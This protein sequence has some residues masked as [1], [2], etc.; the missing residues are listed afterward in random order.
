MLPGSQTRLGPYEI[1]ALLGSTGAGGEMYKATDTRLNRTVAI[2]LLNRPEAERLEGEARVIAALNN[3]YICSIYDIGTNYIVM[4]YVD[5]TALKSPLP[6]K[7]CLRF[8]TQLATA[9][10]A[11]HALGIVH[12]NLKPTNILVSRGNLKLLDFGHIALMSSSPGSSNPAMLTEA[13]AAY[14]SPEQAQGKPTDRRSDIFS[15][16]AVLYEMLSGRRAF[17]GAG[18]RDVIDAIVR[19][20]PRPLEAPAELEH[21]VRHCLRKDPASR[22]QSIEEVTH[23]LKQVPIERP[24]TQPSIAVLPF[25]NLSGQPD[26]D[27]FSAGLTEEIINALTQI[28]GLRVT[29]RTSAFVF[30]KRERDIRKIAHTLGVQTVL[31]GSVRESGSRLRITA[32]LINSTDGYHL[33]S[34]AYDREKADVFAIQDDIAGAIARALL[35]RLYHRRTVNIQA[36]EAYLKARYYM[37]KL[38]PESFAKSR[39]YYEQAIALDPEF[40]LAHCGYAEHYLARSL[41]GILPATEGMPAA[42]ANARKALDINPSLPEAHSVLATVATLYDFDRQEA[43]RRFELSVAREAVASIVRICYAFYFLLPRGRADEAVRMLKRGLTEDPLNSTLHYMLGVALFESDR[44]AEAC[45]EFEEAL[46]LDDHFIW[47]MAVL[48][49]NYLSR[50][51]NTDALAW[52][53]RAHSAMP[54]HAM[55]AGLYAGTLSK[56]GDTPRATRVL[57]QISDGQAYGAPYGLAVF[58]AVA[59]EIDA[60]LHWLEKSIQQR[61]VSGVFQLLHS[62][63]ANRFSS[64]PGWPALVERSNLNQTILPTLREVAT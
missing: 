40:A 31:E 49:M 58:H 38:T 36:Y 27:Y 16:G 4:E 24:E 29:A 47:A 57:K 56:M 39:Q 43:E 20:E 63:L 2:K 59:G 23:A 44:D 6:L 3:P 50:D 14:I 51:M 42:R 30:Q 52:A 12:R 11:E 53:E 7:E 5:G 13:D 18:T 46:E 60:A 21:I 32:Q 45:Q 33:W 64:S 1:T 62:P 15:F 17:E 10:E 54:W 41:V 25:S 9:L 26:N 35:L 37:W 8:A 48:S 34:Q 19:S 61:Y 28:P 55:P 22:F